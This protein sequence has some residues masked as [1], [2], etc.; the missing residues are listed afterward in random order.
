[1]NLLEICIQNPLAGINLSVAQE[2]T[3]TS[4]YTTLPT[5]THKI[6]GLVALAATLVVNSL[7]AVCHLTS[8][9]HLYPSFF[10]IK[11]P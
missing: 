10:E 9:P 5:H 8:D 1:M 6:L 2:K 4:L 7:A 3:H 11:Q